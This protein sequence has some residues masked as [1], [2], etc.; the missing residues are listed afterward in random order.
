M[1]SLA[2]LWALAAG[3]TVSARQA[4]ERRSSPRRILTPF[5]PSPDWREA[6]L[7][8]QL[9]HE[10][11]TSRVRVAAVLMVHQSLPVGIPGSV[12]AVEGPKDVDAPA[13]V[14]GHHPADGAVGGSRL[15]DPYPR[16]DRPE[17]RRDHVL[18]AGHGVWLRDRPEHG[19][20]RASE[21]PDGGDRRVEVPGERL[22]G[23]RVAGLG[24]APAGRVVVVG[25]VVVGTADAQ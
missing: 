8:E 5:L 13:L 22:Q 20:A 7:E 18:R 25:R 15:I 16:G 19:V 3:T 2:G 6:G 24:A 12:R 14:L 11:L 21:P 4:I 17:E 23:G 9:G 1:T 10:L